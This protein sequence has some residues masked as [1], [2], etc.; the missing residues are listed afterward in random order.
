MVRMAGDAGHRRYRLCL[1][2][3]AAADLPATES[4]GPRRSPVGA[5][6][7]RLPPHVVQEPAA[8][9]P[10]ATGGRRT[11]N[12]GHRHDVAQ[13]RR[14]VNYV[15]PGPGCTPHDRCRPDGEVRGFRARHAV[16]GGE[17]LGFTGDD[18]GADGGSQA[19]GL[20][21]RLRFHAG[22]GGNRPACP[23]VALCLAGRRAG[24]GYLATGSVGEA[25]GSRACADTGP[26][27]HLRPRR[28]LE[29]RHTHVDSGCHGHARTGARG[30]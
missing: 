11:G 27:S 24:L 29:S 10:G 21:P 28:A 9:Q 17:Q 25:Q 4:P 1:F 30:H 2:P 26:V 19:Q 3:A 15:L 6:A 12:G 23:A 20:Y 18:P 8:G 13:G 7:D 14:A 22:G 16:A 5:P